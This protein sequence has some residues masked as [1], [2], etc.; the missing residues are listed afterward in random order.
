MD[1]LYIEMSVISHAAARPS[2]DPRVAVLQ[3]QARE[4]WE[5]ERHKFQLVTSQEVLDEAGLGDPEAARRRLTL[6]KGGVPLVTPHPRVKTVA[7]ALV[8]ASLLPWTARVDA[9]HVAAAAVAGVQ[10]LLTQNC[11]HIA[12]AYMLPR[13]Y[14]LLREMGFPNL[15]ICTPAYFLG[16]PYDAA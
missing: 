6:L 8:A 7:D 2:G 11:R 12:N 4:W 9:A 13:V 16:G 15:L 1:S 5:H 14:D 3:Q 10:Y